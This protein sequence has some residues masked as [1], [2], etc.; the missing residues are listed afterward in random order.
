MDVAVQAP[1]DSE[2]M[3]AWVRDHT[4]AVRGFLL[5]MLRRR[6]DADDL[7]QEVFARA[8]QHR[9]RYEERGHARA[10]LLRIADN[11]A[12][13]RLRRKKPEVG[14]TA[15]DGETT[16]EPADHREREPP[17]TLVAGEAAANLQAALDRLSPAQQ[18]VL[19]LRYYGQLSFQEIAETLDCPLN[20]AL[21]HCQ[22]GLKMLRKELEG[23]HS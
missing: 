15:G 8:W 7:V 9:E 17:A 14:L 21:S 23:N 5:A 11:V 2:R 6:D 13:D 1:L 12:C 18:R 10:W 3:V 4:P 20:T 16:Y 22:R 19:L